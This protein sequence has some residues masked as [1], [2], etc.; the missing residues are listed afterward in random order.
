MAETRMRPFHLAL[1]LLVN[2]VWGLNFAAIA[3]TVSALPPILAN[4]LRFLVVLLFLF[5]FL[6]RPVRQKGRLFAI[7]VLLGILH[8]GAVFLAMSRAIDMAPIAIVAQMS[9][10]FSTLLAVL[11][12]GERIGPWRVIGMAVAFS[13]VAILS[14]E[15]GA[16][17]AD[18]GA[19]L[20]TLFSAFVF[21]LVAIL[22]RR[23]RDTHSMTVQVWV[24][25]AA[26]PGS[27]MLSALFETGQG[28]ALARAPVTAFLAVA[29]SGIFASI[30]GHGL[31]YWLLQRYEVST[32]APYMLLAPLFA[33]LS[34]VLLLGEHL[35]AGDL[36]GG[37]VTLGGVLLITIRN[38]KRQPLGAGT[39]PPT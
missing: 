34:A 12:L 20:L 35:D 14:F 16:G 3:Y 13:G 28:A 2:V 21:A 1:M 5:P 24:A 17:E 11:L 25:A 15:P 23:L 37:A 8:F 33:V 9:V 36:W 29:Y 31:T 22:M 38:R 32:V 19:I 10:P 27:L 7:A 18:L 39:T 30:I 4:A 26:V 6:R